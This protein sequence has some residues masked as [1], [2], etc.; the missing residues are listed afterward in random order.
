MSTGSENSTIQEEDELESILTD[1]SSI[2]LTSINDVN[3][4]KLFT[5][6]ED[7]ENSFEEDDLEQKEVKLIDLYRQGHHM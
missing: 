7:N 2:K 4:C 6:Y 3:K 5:I 1:E